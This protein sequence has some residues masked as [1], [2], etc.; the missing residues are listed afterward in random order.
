M[1]DLPFIFSVNVGSE[2]RLLGDVRR[3]Y[4][5][6]LGLGLGVGVGAGEVMMR[7]GAVMGVGMGGMRTTPA[8][9]PH[10]VRRARVAGGALEPIR[11]DMCLCLLVL[12]VVAVAVAVAG[13]DSPLPLPPWPPPTQPM[14]KSRSN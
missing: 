10:R 14:S 3:H 9:S 11:W 13:A 8:R 6:G 2:D 12:L 7:E 4:G 1:A 5:L